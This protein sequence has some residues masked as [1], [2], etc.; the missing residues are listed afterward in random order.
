MYQRDKYNSPKRRNRRSGSVRKLKFYI[1]KQIDGKEVVLFTAKTL[2]HANH[3][4]KKY[5]SKGYYQKSLLKFSYSDQN[6][7]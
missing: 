7:V 4:V 6:S 3:Y 1:C 5:K 2:K